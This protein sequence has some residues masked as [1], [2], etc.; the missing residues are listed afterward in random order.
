MTDPVYYGAD[1]DVNQDGRVDHLIFAVSADAA[2]RQV[3]SELALRS[4]AGASMVGRGQPTGPDGHVEALSYRLGNRESYE[5]YLTP[6]GLQL[7]HMALCE[8]IDTSDAKYNYT[9][10][11]CD[12]PVPVQ[13]LNIKGLHLPRGQDPVGAGVRAMRQF[14]S[15]IIGR[16]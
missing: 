6:Q 5:V 11:I 4:G 14:V 1:V 2:G 13:T 9:N 12:Y 8:P 15:D 16:P 10:E 7:K 3:V